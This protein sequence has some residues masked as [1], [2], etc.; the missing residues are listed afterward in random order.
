MIISHTSVVDEESDLTIAV[1]SRFWLHATSE[2]DKFINASA[3]AELM[4]PQS[5]PIRE[6]RTLH[7]FPLSYFNRIMQ[8]VISL[9]R[10]VATSAARLDKLYG[11]EAYLEVLLFESVWHMA[12]QATG[13][14]LHTEILLETR[15]SSSLWTNLFSLLL[16]SVE[17]DKS[18][19]TDTLNGGIVLPPIIFLA[20]AVIADCSKTQNDSL[21]AF[22]K[23]W[24][25]TKMIHALSQCIIKGV[26]ENQ[27]QLTRE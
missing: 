18:D 5:K 10:F 25:R 20:G 24:A 14:T 19:F 13:S 11:I 21:P 6:Y 12:S 1:L 17:D 22:A 23:L 3:L 9:D 4:R 7:P 26:L 2:G 16:R 15:N 8:G 27:D